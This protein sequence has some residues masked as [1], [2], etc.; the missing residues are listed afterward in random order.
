[1]KRINRNY[2][3]EFDRDFEFQ[4]YGDCTEAHP[5]RL[6]KVEKPKEKNQKRKNNTENQ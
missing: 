1:M 5:Y 3:T 2:E 6:L 4:D